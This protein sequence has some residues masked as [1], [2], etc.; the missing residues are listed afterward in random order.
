[1]KFATSLPWAGTVSTPENLV[2]FALAAEQAGIDR[3]KIG[4]HLLYPKVITTA[5]PYTAAGAMPA[6]DSPQRLE[7][8]TTFAYLAAIT[9]RLRFHPGVA[10]LPL[11]SPVAT[12]KATAT[13]DYLSNGRFTL[14]IGVGWMREEFEAL[15]VPFERRGQVLDEYIEVIR[16]LFAGGRPFEGEFVSL[17]EVEFA[18]LPVQNPYPIYI[19]SGVSDRALRRVARSADGWSPIGVSLANLGEALARLDTYL[20]EV[21]RSRADVELSIMVGGPRAQALGVEGLLREIGEAEQLGAS[22][23]QVEFG[24]RNVADIGEAIESLH[25]FAS[26]VMP[27]SG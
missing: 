19:G 23:V 6:T 16:C 5:Y 9:T 14:E 12:A 1:L 25:W 17:P 26:E 4:E 20:G 8:F 7:M 13:L 10:I 15:R 3:V 18:P 2:R 21:G 11:R 24:Q 22:C 27:R